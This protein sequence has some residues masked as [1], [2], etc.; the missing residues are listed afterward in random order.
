M[1]IVVFAGPKLFGGEIL[2]QQTQS[3]LQPTVACQS[4]QLVQDMVTLKEEERWLFSFTLPSL[5]LLLV[6]LLPLPPSP[7]CTKPCGFA[8]QVCK[9]NYTVSAW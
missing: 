2:V 6:I 1:S 3:L 8:E 5:H 4:V 7:Y 9:I